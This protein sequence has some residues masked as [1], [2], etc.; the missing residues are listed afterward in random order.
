MVATLNIISK[1]DENIQ[2]SRTFARLIKVY[3][4]GVHRYKRE[5]LDYD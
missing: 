4:M 5:N 3:A 2:K 1:S